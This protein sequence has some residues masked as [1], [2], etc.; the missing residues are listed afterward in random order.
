MGCTTGMPYVSWAILLSGRQDWLLCQFERPYR[1]TDNLC[2]LSW[3]HRIM[4]MIDNDLRIRPFHH[5]IVRC[6]V[7]NPSNESRN[8][9]RLYRT[10]CL[11][12]LPALL[13]GSEWVTIWNT[14]PYFSH[15]D[16][17]FTTTKRVCLK[18]LSKWG[19]TSNQKL[20][21]EQ[22]LPIPNP[23]GDS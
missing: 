18:R 4:R 1:R 7:P 11:L 9:W 8:A 10:F 14:P 20:V 21:S 16:Y 6:P 17:F 19:T 2:R 23:E 13:H 3:A 5:R 15:P 22:L 12:L